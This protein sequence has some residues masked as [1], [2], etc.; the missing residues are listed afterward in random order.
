[1]KTRKVLSIVL[2]M[3]LILT[4]INVGF[5]QNETKTNKEKIDYLV[6]KG[7]VK[8]DAKGLRL[9]DPITREEF[10]AMLI[11]SLGKEEE[12][13]TVLN[14]PSEFK[15]LS[16]NN[17]SNGYVN[18]A[19]ALK[20]ISGYTDKTFRPRKNVNYKEAIKMLAV[21]A[22]GTDIAQ[23]SEGDWSLPYISY[24]AKNGILKDL[25]IADY[26]KQASREDVFVMIYNFIY[27][28]KLKEVSKLTA[29]VTKSSENS[30]LSEKQVEIT[31]LKSS[32]DSFKQGGSYIVDINPNMDPLDVIG[33]VY[34]MNVND[35]NM[36]ATYRESSLANIEM[37]PITSRGSKLFV[38]D[39]KSDST[40]LEEKNALAEQKFRG[41]S[42]AGKNY[43]TFSDFAN[44]ANGKADLAF[45]TSV[46]G[47][48]IY[49]KAFNFDDIMPIISCEKGAVKAV[50]DESGNIMKRNLTKA[51]MYNAGTLKAMDPLKLEKYDILH[52]FK[53]DEAIVV[54]EKV[55]VNA[56]KYKISK[57]G[58]IINAAGKDYLLSDE[59]ARRA[60]ATVDEKV[61]TQVNSQNYNNEVK[62]LLNEKTTLAL[63]IFNNVQVI[64][65]KLSFD[66]DV[67][68]IDRVSTNAISLISRD[69]KEVRVQDSL[70]LKIYRDGKEVRLAELYPQDLVYVI[71]NKDAVQ[72]IFILNSIKNYDKDFK[73]LDKDGKTYKVYAPTK[74]VRRS[75][76]FV[77]GKEINLLENTA[78]YNLVSVGKDYKVEAIS[79]DEVKNAS[80][81][82]T[83]MAYIF[84]IKDLKDKDVT[85]YEKFHGDDASP[86]AIIFKNLEKKRVVKKED[87]IELRS[88]YDSKIDKTFEGYDENTNLQ[89]YKTNG[90]TF[91]NAK[92]GDIVK[93]SFDQDGK[94]LR[95]DKLITKLSEEYTVENVLYDAGGNEILELK[96]SKSKTVKFNTNEKRLV[97]GKNYAKYSVIKIALNENNEVYVINVIK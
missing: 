91:E 81:N 93:L 5:A 9:K 14:V 97:F 92:A 22:G 90:A 19:T 82:K 58:S 52:Y 65:G 59:K 62:L 88:D 53:S 16:V 67:F 17:W 11:R 74:T 96:D 76:I 32:L 44:V 21:A 87:I 35:S 46:A 64:Y 27:E 37:A 94:I 31:V 38:G 29:L 68:V 95:V 2:A 51:F 69:G 25:A 8:G 43:E 18:L 73:A 60:V 33:R 86:V 12:A 45:V 61:F 85:K 40:I 89:V 13:K 84:T 39:S 49:V 70:D 79:L 78:L 7:L 63:D 34:D 41:A 24:A 36:I 20:I 71:Y 42:L 57:D 6:D 1:M 72:K 77:S 55:E 30:N 75:S 54:R 4:S 48:V 83:V 80:F 66:E 47:K 28:N 56:G 23:A 26:A 15:D 10:A 50:D 3:F